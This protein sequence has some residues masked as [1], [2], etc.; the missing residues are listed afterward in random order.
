METK[1]SYYINK[2][3]CQEHHVSNRNVKLIKNI[4]NSF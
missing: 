4:F 2:L 1:L 3:I